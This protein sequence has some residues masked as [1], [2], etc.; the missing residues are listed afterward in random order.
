MTDGE[1][2][3]KI[4][5]KLGKMTAF[6]SLSKTWPSCL[7]TGILGKKEHVNPVHSSAKQQQGQEA[8]E[9]KMWLHSKR[10]IQKRP[11][12]ADG[13]SRSTQLTEE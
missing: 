7:T 10:E 4:R 2:D 13:M 8:P 12:Q 1:F 11:C 9:H 3:F 5:D 6:R